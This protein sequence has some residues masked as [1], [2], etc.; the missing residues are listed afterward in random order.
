MLEEE[1]A[2]QE[3]RINTYLK[4]YGLTKIHSW[5]YWADE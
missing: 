2:K 1:K 3:K 4:K 5:S